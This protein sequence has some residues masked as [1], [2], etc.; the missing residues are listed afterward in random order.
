M[1]STI[2]GYSEKRATWTAGTHLSDP[3]LVKILGRRE[4]TSGVDV[5]RVS[6]LGFPPV[7]RGTNVISNT[8]AKLPLY[9][10]RN[11]ADGGKERA[12][13]HP[14]YRLL[15]HRAN[16]TL[17]ALQLKRTLTAHAI[18]EGNGYAWIERTGGGEPVGLWPLRPHQTTVVGEDGRL[19]YVTQ[20]NG[21]HWRLQPNQVLHVRGL[22]HDGFVGYSLLEIAAEALGLGIAAQQFTGAF[23][24]NGA[25][26]DG[27]L[28]YPGKLSAEARE[29]LRRNWD[30]MHT[31]TDKSFRIAVFEEGLKYQ[32]L[33]VAAKDAQL[34]ESRGFDAKQ[35]ANLL[36]LPPHL[37]GDDS[38]TS[39]ASLEQEMR[40]LL[41][42]SFD[43]WLTTWEDECRTKLLTEPEQ[44]TDSHSI[45]FMREAMLRADSRTTIE[46]LVTEV[47]NGLAT[48]NEA[49]QKLNLPGI[50]ELGDRFRKPENIGWL[51]AEEEGPDEV[52]DMPPEPPEDPPAD[53][54]ADDTPDDETPAEG[55]RAR[56]L[57]STI[58]RAVRRCCVHARRASKDHRRFGDW[59]EHWWG[60][61]VGSVAEMVGEVAEVCG[62]EPGGI[63][64][65]IRRQLGLCWDALCRDSTPRSL[66]ADCE[67]ACGRLAE[68]VPEEI[69]RIIYGE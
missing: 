17:T 38:R 59:A 69:T 40:S 66:E 24:G 27:M 23:F 9:V 10:Y 32:P 52:P 56:L 18:L 6:V 46:T 13:T 48:A 47:N 49:R 4:V 29:N 67:R 42:H 5:D 34:I 15:R 39:Y 26:T 50:G 3:A 55:A 37:V 30:K 20:V 36:N 21:E 7:W 35:I 28:M 22:S 12:R 31:G 51:D 41:E 57:R 62:V 14:A 61:H 63:V 65:Q 25:H 60:D 33:T 45:E 16:D 54:P 2:L 19:Q 44:Q 1:I 64:E 53:E 43:P 68:L 8:V 11:Q 58:G